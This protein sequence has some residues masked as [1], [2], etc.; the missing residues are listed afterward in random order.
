MN[1]T[2]IENIQK[3][4]KYHNFTSEVK[5]F[6]DPL[7]VT[8][9]IY[10]IEASSADLSLLPKYHYKFK[11]E[12][13]ATH[14]IRP[15]NT[16]E[17]SKVMK[18]C[19]EYSMPVTFR[20]AG[21]SCYSASTPTKGGVLI[22]VRRMNKIHDV[23]VENLTVKCDAGISWLKLIESL[24]DYGL[25]PKCYPTSYKSSCVAGF[26]V[27]SGKAGIGVLKYGKM[28]DT[29]ISM[30]FVKPDGSIEKITKDS[31]GELKLDD[32]IGSFG[33]YGA[34]AELELSVTTLKPSLK[35]LGYSFSTFSK[36]LEFFH[37]IKES[38]DNKPLFLSMSDKNF[39][40]YAHWT[41]PSR[42]YFVFAVYYDDEGITSKNIAFGKELA[43]K[44]DGL[45]VED[46]YLKEKWSDISGTEA[47]LGRWCRNLVFQ[48]YW[49]SDERTESFYSD[50]S[51]SLLKYSYKNGF[52]MMAGSEGGNRI[53]IFGLT[54]IANPREFFG[55]KAVFHDISMNSYTNGDSVYTIGVVNTMYHMKFHPEEVEKIKNLKSKLDPEDLVNSYRL[56]KKKMKFWRVNLLFTLA[57]FL[58]RSG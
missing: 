34:I 48:E 4:D 38:K 52:Y 31:Q 49:I 54:S 23:N 57:K 41:F 29:I 14:V 47:N 42:N 25:V 1:A 53:K 5:E 55:I 56:I 20:A 30:T 35:I 22:D 28:M 39:E 18:K 9:D 2:K 7:H 21:S 17:L 33:V 44:M 51:H 40:K 6:I 11:E 43:S 13:Q 37:A 58:Y 50:Y 24:M 32:I 45:E 36:G 26:A 12:Y 46:W 19:Q 3:E 15:A 27:T 8:T 10:E 16:E